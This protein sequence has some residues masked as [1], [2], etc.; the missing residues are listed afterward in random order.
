MITAGDGGADWTGAVSGGIGGTRSTDALV[1]AAKPA[2]LTADKAP[3]TATTPETPPIVHDPT[4]L[5]ALSRS[6][7]RYC[8]T[9]VVPAAVTTTAAVIAP[10]CRGSGGGR[11]GCRRRAGAPRVTRPGPCSWRGVGDHNDFMD[12]RRLCRSRI[13]AVGPKRRTWEL[14]GDGVL[15]SGAERREGANVACGTDA[16]DDA[17]QPNQYGRREEVRASMTAQGGVLQ[18][19]SAATASDPCH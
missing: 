5:K 11:P 17:G 4:R 6:S 3:V 8:A 10:R 2:A 15:S 19:A 9:S 16:G 12:G 7:G 14:G 13:E 1:A 18:V